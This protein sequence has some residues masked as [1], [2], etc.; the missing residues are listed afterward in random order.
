VAFDKTPTTWLANWSEN[1]TNISLPSASLPETDATECDGTT[2]DFRKVMLAF[3]EAVY[4]HYN[5]LATADRPAKMTITRSTSV[6]DTTGVI[7][8]TYAAAFLT[9]AAVGG[10]EVVAEA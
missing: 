9:E 8:R 6:N 10:I 1:G 4:Q 2:G 5:G 7:T 3:M